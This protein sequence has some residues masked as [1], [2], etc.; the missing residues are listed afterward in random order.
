MTL[1]TLLPHQAIILQI[2]A[3]HGAD[4]IRIFGSAARDELTAE[5][6][7]DILVNLK[8]GYSLLDLVALKQDL[9]DALGIEVDVVTE[10]ALSPYIRDQVLEEAV[11]I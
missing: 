3:N 7:L 10:A 5:S 2:A 4:N 6:D 11:A 9:E 1:P 8:P